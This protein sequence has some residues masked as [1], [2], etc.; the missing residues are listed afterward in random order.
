MLVLGP[1]W[2]TLGSPWVP[3]GVPSWSNMA[4]RGSK[5][6]PEWYQNEVWRQIGDLLKTTKNLSVLM[7]F[8]GLEGVGLMKN[9]GW[10][11]F[12]VALGA[13]GRLLK[14]WEGFGWLWRPSMLEA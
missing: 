14:V 11:G 4:L 8:R 7:V 5:W 12:G 1:F 10:E 3:L 13:L 6:G 2:S 9:G